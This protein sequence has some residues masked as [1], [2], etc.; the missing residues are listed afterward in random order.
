MIAATVLF[1]PCKP[2]VPPAGLCMMAAIGETFGQLL[3]CPPP[4]VP[5]AD[6]SAPVKAAPSFPAELAHARTVDAPILAVLAAVGPVLRGLRQIHGSQPAM[7][8]VQLEDYTTDAALIASAPLPAAPS[9]A[10]ALVP[11]TFA[12]LTPRRADPETAG[13]RAPAHVN[14]IVV[15]VALRVPDAPPIG[16]A[17]ATRETITALSPPQPAFEALSFTRQL[18]LSRDTLWLDRLAR[19]IVSAASADGRLRF[20]LSPPTLGRMEVDVQRAEQGLHVQLTTHTDAARAIIADAQPRLIDEMRALGV[21]VADSQVAADPSRQ[22]PG[23]RPPATP[24]LI[25]A[26]PE[27]DFKPESPVTHDGRFA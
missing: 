13:S 11:E 2:L 14:A 18:D 1:T 8:S 10:A 5:P 15:E 25:E 27:T 21:R 6:A 20:E 23:S 22:Q 16:P 26:A 12:R 3:A 24:I 17:P 9:S 19:D 4:P 7:A